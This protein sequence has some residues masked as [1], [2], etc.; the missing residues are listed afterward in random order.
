MSSYT[1]TKEESM[2]NI[3]QYV[4]DFV[5]GRVSAFDFIK[6]V[7]EDPAILDWLQSLIPSDRTIRTVVRDEAEEYPFQNCRIE[8]VPYR[9]REVI[10]SMCYGRRKTSLECRL[11]MHS[12]IS[13]IVQEAFPEEDLKADESLHNL[14]RFLLESCPSYIGGSEV[15]ESGILEQII[16]SI[17]KDLSASKRKKMAKEK[18]KE[19]FH[20][21][22]KSY[23]RWIQ[24]PEWPMSN[25]EPMQY[26]RTER[27]NIEFQTL[28]FL[29]P[30]TGEERAVFDAH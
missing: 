20:I 23:P 24:A 12:L 5:E 17:P 21:T 18:I 28:Y 25:G 19:R 7:D 30:K 14:H 29:D 3:K 15:D 9:I 10:D 13:E 6:R 1:S 27:S 26:V 4:F 2:E 16:D 8:T 11:N 22:G